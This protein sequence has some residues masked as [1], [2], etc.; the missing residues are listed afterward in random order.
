MS[1]SSFSF[2]GRLV[3]ALA[4]VLP[5]ACASVPQLEEITGPRAQVRVVTF[6]GTNT[7]LQDWSEKTCNSGSGRAFAI[8][9]PNANALYDQGAGRRV[10]MPLIEDFPPK[11]VTE[12]EVP[13]T[14]R[15]YLEMKS[16][17]ISGAFGTTLLYSWCVRQ[18]SFLPEAGQMYE[19]VY[20]T[21]ADPLAK[22]S[23]SVEMVKVVSA[24]GGGYVRKPF[25]DFLAKQNL[26]KQ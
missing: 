5:V 4:S 8:I 9:G 21:G 11:Q 13:A 25:F 16:P 1:S 14:G 3:A 12:L 23:C 18:I 2:Q 22:G 24:D 15:Y 6:P 7:A 10:G 17:S 20:R 19:V 26:C